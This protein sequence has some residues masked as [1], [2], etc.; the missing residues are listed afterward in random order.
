MAIITFYKRK[1]PRKFFRISW[2][3]KSLTLYNLYTGGRSSLFNLWCDENIPEKLSV[4]SRG[5]STR[6]GVSTLRT[7]PRVTCIWKTP[8]YHHLGTESNKVSRENFG[9]NP[10]ICLNNI[11]YFIYKIWITHRI[12]KWKTAS[13]CLKNF[14]FFRTKKIFF[15]FFSD[16]YTLSR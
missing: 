12:K 16:F 9:H 15:N 3:W 1:P 14:W 10:T 11:P 13:C 7:V 6:E 5:V 8:G 4:Y 2:Q